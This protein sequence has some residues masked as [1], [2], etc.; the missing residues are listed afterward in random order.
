MKKNKIIKEKNPKKLKDFEPSPE[1]KNPNSEL[2]TV[3]I[4]AC[5]VINNTQTNKPIYDLE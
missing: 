3:N 1:G 4:P 2:K 5:I